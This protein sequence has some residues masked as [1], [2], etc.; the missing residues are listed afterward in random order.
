[1]FVCESQKSGEIH[2]ED[3]IYVT[4]RHLYCQIGRKSPEN[5]L[6]STFKAQTASYK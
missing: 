5:Q 2:P 6:N 1:M 4:L 3:Y